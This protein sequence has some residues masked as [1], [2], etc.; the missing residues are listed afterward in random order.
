MNKSDKIYLPEDLSI[1]K[2]HDLY[3]EKYPNL[4]VSVIE[5]SSITNSTFLSAIQ[6]Q[7]PAPYATN[8]ML[9]LKS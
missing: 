9:R 1:S 6:E 5:K 4:P 8:I 3:K 2:C 7:T